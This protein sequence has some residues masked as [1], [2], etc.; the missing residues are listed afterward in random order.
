MTYKPTELNGRSALV[1][2]ASRGIGRA[3]A[4]ALAAHGAT[5]GVH[6]NRDEEAAEATAAELAG[7]NHWVLQADLGDPAAVIKLADEAERFLGV[8]DILVNNAGVFELHP[9]LEGDTTSWLEKWQRTVDVN[10]LGPACLC[11]RIGARMAER[12]GGRIINITSR[13][14]Y[15][16]EPLAPAY[17]ASKAGLN[18]LS[19]SL[20]QAL[21]PH[22]VMVTAVAPG[23]VETDMTASHMVG[24]EG[25][26]IRAQSPMGRA[27]T[28]EEIADVVAFLAATKAE[29]LTGAVI[30]VNGASY[31]R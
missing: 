8:V 7:E 17:G 19:Q 2:G 21:G 16:G 4:N 11:Q 29:F 9:V 18:S 6:Y 24:E 5:V 12:G 20:A 15:R 13:G 25:D 28:S 14:A 22:G 27:A 26:A 30:D 23:W 3:I 31:L 1:T 10:L